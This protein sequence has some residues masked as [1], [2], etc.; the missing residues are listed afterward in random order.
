MKTC[1][2]IGLFI[3]C[4]VDALY[5]EV[6]I[7]TVELLERLGHELDYPDEQTCCGQ[8]HF[9]AGHRRQAAALAERFCRVFDN[10]DTVV[11]PSAS[12]TAMVREHYEAL[13]GD[14]AVCRRVFE[15][16]EFLT[17]RL[18]VTDVGAQ[19]AGR[20]A[21]HVGCHGLRHLGIRPS[22]EQLLA[23]VEGLDVV[24]VESDEWC[25]GFGGT[26][27]VKYPEVSAA[28]GRRKLA[29]VTAADVDYLVSTDSSCLMHLGGLLDRERRRRPRLLHIAQVL[30]GSTEAP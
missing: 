24:S 19:L 30:A 3:P 12:C 8:A 14:R 18:G 23:G 10:Y 16:C 25:C 7:A 4:F 2:R 15:L 5:P 27:S 13:I 28:M 6:G 20:A 29:G 1:V 26:F 22:A 17:E 11:C 9:N 21:L